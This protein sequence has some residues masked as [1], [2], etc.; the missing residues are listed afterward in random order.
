[1]EKDAAMTSAA[2]MESLGEL[3]VSGRIVDA[4]LAFMV[5]EGVILIAYQR[6][7]GR[8]IAPASVIAN[9]AAGGGLLLALRA[10]IA[11]WG[12]LA[13]SACLGLSFAAHLADLQ[14]R[15]RN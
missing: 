2:V 15:W 9:L 13:I 7:T 3:F 10:T 5:I 4:I 14:R 6:R 8:G 11:G 12:V 1:V